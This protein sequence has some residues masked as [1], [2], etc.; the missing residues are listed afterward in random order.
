M[1][2]QEKTI[3]RRN[4]LI[5]MGGGALGV[6]LGAGIGRMVWLEDK[7]VLA[8]PASEGYLLVDPNKCMGC[9]SCMLAC[10]LVH[11]GRESLSLAR[12]QVLYDPFEKYPESIQIAQCR[13]CT[14]PPCVEACPTGALH[15]DK[16]NG[17][18]RLVDYAKCIGC[19]RCAEACP[20]LPSRALW[21]FEN[22][23]AQKCDLCLN[24]PYWNEI[25]GPTGKR[26]CEEVCPED[27]IKFTSEIPT[28]VGDYGYAVNLRG[29]LWPLDKLD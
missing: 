16:K 23:H 28:Q 17:G 24:T 4:F 21:N 5:A 7:E 12:I 15:A 3:S 19:Q 9:K 6:A 8:I 14:Y 1:A 27:A 18:V 22:S 13:Q 25:G 26:A 20:F 11:E 10:S 2:D 29:P